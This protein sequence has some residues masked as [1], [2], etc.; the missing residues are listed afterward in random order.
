MQVLAL[1]V[2]SIDS[3]YVVAKAPHRNYP[4]CL[5]QG[6][7]LSILCTSALSIAERIQHCGINDEEL[8][9]EFQ[10]LTNSLIGR[11]LHYQRVLDEHRIGYLY[12]GKFSEDDLVQLVPSDSDSP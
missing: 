3:N 5:I 6:D 12:G 7:S 8:L 10:L 1:E 4:G 11:V 2:Y 9:G